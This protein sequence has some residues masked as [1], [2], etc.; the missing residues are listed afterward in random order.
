MAARLPLGRSVPVIPGV[1]AL[2]HVHNPG[3]AFSLLGDVPL[4]AP[5][6]VTLTLLFLL[7]YNKARWS[8]RPTTQAALAFLGGGAVANLIDRIRVGAV[9]DFIDVH[10]WPVFNLADAAVTIGAVLLL[11]ILLRGDR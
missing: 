6:A 5:V 1:L 4:L 3:V 9:V 7:F 11:L 8:R 10:I 2:T